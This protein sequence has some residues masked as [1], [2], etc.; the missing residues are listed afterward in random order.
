M[1]Q[2]ESGKKAPDASE[3]GAQAAG[4]P[5]A[6]GPSA[7]DVLQALCKKAD[8]VGHHIEKKQ[9]VDH[10]A[11][12]EGGNVLDKEKHEAAMA[13]F[14]G[15]VDGTGA[16]VDQDKFIAA[17]DT[18]AGKKKEGKEAK[19]GKPKAKP[20]A[21]PQV[22]LGTKICV[23]NLPEDT[24][25]EKLTTMFES[26]GKIGKV[27]LKTKEGGKSK[28]FGFIQYGSAEEASK[29][30]AE[31]N[32]KEVDGKKLA[33]TL[34]F[35][36]TEKGNTEKGKGK[37]KDGKGKDAKGAAKGKDKG[38]GKGSAGNNS[39]AAQYQ[40]YQAQM[41]NWYALQMQTAMMAQWQAAQ[42]QQWYAQQAYAGGGAVSAGAGGDKEYSGIIKRI[43]DR[44]GYGFIECAELK[45][46]WK[47]DKNPDGR[48]IYI[49]AN[50]IPESCK[51]VNSKVKF[52]LSFNAKGH[53]QASSCSPA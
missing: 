34:A 31:M 35:D 17:C 43:T 12:D 39:Q 36:S 21:K 47:D 23:R 29:A 20:K 3:A 14:A 49:A 18:I 51:E 25:S 19:E 22:E 26:F 38:K 15:I 27:D 40:A 37:G 10:L 45:G 24:T 1:G 8:E 11:M 42:M 32:D 33:V 30:M 48:D 16:V 52:T 50:L 9:L 6:T 44:N 41:Q 53:P 2:S 13:K 28:G 46:K 5:A 4:A 7:A